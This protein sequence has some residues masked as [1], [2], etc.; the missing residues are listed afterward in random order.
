MTHE[1]IE[2]C[3]FCYAK[4][5]TVWPGMNEYTCGQKISLSGK[6]IRRSKLCLKRENSMLKKINQALRAENELLKATTRQ[7]G[8]DRGGED[9]KE[10]KNWWNLSVML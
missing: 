2:Q 6:P 8:R 5:Y 7:A 3:P 9:M 10:D 1:Q 4:L